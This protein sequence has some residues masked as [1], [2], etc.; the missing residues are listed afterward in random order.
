[1]SERIRKRVISLQYAFPITRADV[2]KLLQGTP[3]LKSKD[4][5]EVIMLDNKSV[6]IK[7]THR[8]DAL[9]KSFYLGRNQCVQVGADGLKFD[10]PIMK[11][12]VE[13]EDM[14]TK[15]SE[16]EGVEKKGGEEGDDSV[17]IKVEGKD[18]ID[19]INS[20]KQTIQETKTAVTPPHAKPLSQIKEVLPIPVSQH[21]KVVWRVWQQELY[22]QITT[23]R[24]DGRRIIWYYDYCGGTGKTFFCDHIQEFITRKITILTD[25]SIIDL[26]AILDNMKKGTAPIAIIFN[27]GAYDSGN[28]VSEKGEIFK[29]LELFS[30]AFRESWIVVFSNTFPILDTM[31]MN[32]W[33]IRRSPLTRLAETARCVEVDGT[34]TTNHRVFVRSVFKR[35]LPKEVKL[36]GEYRNLMRKKDILEFYVG[37]EV[38]KKKEKKAVVEENVEEI[39]N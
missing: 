36:S 28:I 20:I 17:E 13:N 34:R 12:G 10:H 18:T 27:I 22:S 6:Q 30:D 25:D 2:E 9:L 38:I 26:K 14:V 21:H 4:P 11:L 33:V 31:S 23:P 3:F 32:R 8:T 39:D 7:F 5:Y 16:D 37:G 35:I 1:M 19:S 24:T 15:K 29:Y